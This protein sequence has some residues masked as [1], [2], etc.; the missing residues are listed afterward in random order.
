MICATTGEGF[1][2][3]PVRGSEPSSI[4]PLS[5]LTA[6][7]PDGSAGSMCS[8]AEGTTGCGRLAATPV[9]NVLD[10]CPSGL[11]SGSPADAKTSARADPKLCGVSAP[12]LGDRVGADP[13]I[14]TL[15]SEGAAIRIISEAKS[16]TEAGVETF[17]PDH[18]A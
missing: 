4:P 15:V 11:V 7:G 12:A 5:V 3:M 6:M 8:G 13:G 10:S 18:I 2:E 17:T 1:R 16:G 9:I 14:E